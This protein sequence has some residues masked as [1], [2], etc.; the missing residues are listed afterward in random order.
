MASQ[1]EGVGAAPQEPWLAVEE[2]PHLPVIPRGGEKRWRSGWS[3]HSVV[4]TA[5][6]T[7]FSEV[8]S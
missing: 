8:G 4:N 1:V 2:R 7:D 5:M 3:L 6:E